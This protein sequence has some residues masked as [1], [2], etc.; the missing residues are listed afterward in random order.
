MT[1]AAPPSRPTGLS[2]TAGNGRVTLT[3]N[4]NPSSENVTSYTLYMASQSG[5]TAINYA[6]LP[7]GMMHAT[8]TTTYIHTGLTNGTTYY[9]V[10]TSVSSAGASAQSSEV[11][12]TLGGIANIQKISAG[13]YHTCALTTSGG[14]KCWGLNT[15]GQLGNGGTTDSSTPV[16]VTGLTS[17]VSAVSAGG[18]HTCAL[19]TSF[20]LKCWGFNGEGLLGD[21]WGTRSASTPVNV[22][23]LGP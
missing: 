11:S 5:V 6:S 13:A 9:F 22:I 23:G 10:V 2:A 7:N 21:G 8:T 16:D 12:A 4:A 20:G 17:G 15:Y 19:T 3:W 14:L 1:A 18:G